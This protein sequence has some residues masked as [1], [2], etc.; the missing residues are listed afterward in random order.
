MNVALDVAPG[1]RAV[2]LDPDFT[3]WRRLAPSES[4][5][6]LRDAVAAPRLNVLVLDKT[7]N[8]EALKFAGAF[9]EGEVRAVAAAEAAASRGALIVVG[10]SA[11]VDEYLHAHNLPERPEQVSSGDIQCWAIA[12]PGSRMVI[13][14]LPAEAGA[15]NAALSQ[16]ARRLPHLS[17]YSWVTFQDN[18]ISGRGNWPAMSPRIPVQ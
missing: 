3:V 2:Q 11:A 5:P 8:T 18:R 15:A 12:D 4:P 17:R 1:A 16:L 9:G 10:H 7:L 6:I 13:V 14:S